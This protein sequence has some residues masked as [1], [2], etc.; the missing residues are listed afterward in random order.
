MHGEEVRI[1]KRAASSRCNIIDF[2]GRYIAKCCMVSDSAGDNPDMDRL[3]SSSDILLL[4]WMLLV[5]EALGLNHPKLQRMHT[6][7]LLW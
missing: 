2:C 4:V 6:G 1:E 3:Q 7:T 5:V